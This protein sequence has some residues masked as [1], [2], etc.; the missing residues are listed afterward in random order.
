MAE[1]MINTDSIEQTAILFGGYDANVRLIEEAFGVDISTKDS[2]SSGGNAV[3]SAGPIPIM[4]E[5]PRKRLPILNA[6]PL[7]TGDFPKV[8]LI[9]SSEW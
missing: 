7:L 1:K 6:L 2:D 4:S 8:M 9:M 3:S 5:R